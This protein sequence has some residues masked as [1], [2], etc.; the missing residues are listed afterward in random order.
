MVVQQD[1]FGTVTA[2][3]PAGPIT[4]ED[5]RQ[6]A[7][8]LAQQLAAPNPR[9]VINM[10]DVPYMDSRG[11]EILLDLVRELRD[12]GLPLKLAELTPTCR[13]I[14]DLTELLGEFEIYDSIEDAVR[15]FL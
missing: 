7:D 13:E 10:N 9:L 15:S 2:V 4:D 8:A 1:K 14:L 12:R 11:L 3:A 6:F 5:S